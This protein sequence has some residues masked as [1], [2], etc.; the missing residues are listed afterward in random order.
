MD[1]GEVGNRLGTRDGG[2][3]VAAWRLDGDRTFKAAVGES[4][5]GKQ[6]WLGGDDLVG[7]SGRE[8]RPCLY[9]QFIAEQSFRLGGRGTRRRDGEVEVDG[10]AVLERHSPTGHP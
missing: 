10:G 8:R 9:G 4:R 5:E 1:P 7:G 6:A 3:A 2:G